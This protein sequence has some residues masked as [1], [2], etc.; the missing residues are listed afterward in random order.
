MGKGLGLG[1]GSDQ[2]LTKLICTPDSGLQILFWEVLYSEMIKI[3]LKV[4]V[5]FIDSEKAKHMII[6]TPYLI[7]YL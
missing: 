1:L 7:V 4:K 2:G 6:E 3:I 5:K